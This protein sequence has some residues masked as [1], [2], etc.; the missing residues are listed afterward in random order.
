M[1]VWGVRSISFSESFAYVLNKWSP[2]S[3]PK[4]SFSDVFYIEMV[5]LAWNG[6]KKFDPG[7]FLDTVVGW[8][9]I[10]YTTEL[11]FEDSLL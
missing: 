6:S 11:A 5:H 8:V 10:E 3:D 9:I 1:C 7:K 4:P 2:L